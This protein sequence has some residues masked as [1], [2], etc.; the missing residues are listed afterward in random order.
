M[1]FAQLRT[2][3]GYLNGEVTSALQKAIRRGEEG[4][5]LFWATELELAGYGEY[6]WNR[7]RIISVEDVGVGEPQAVCQVAALYGFWS[8]R[9]KKEKAALKNEGREIPPESRLYLIMAVQVLARAKKCRMVDHAYMTFYE[10]DRTSPEVKREV[11][12]YAL[13]GHTAA[14]RRL[15]RGPEFFLTESSKLEN[16]ADLEDLYRELGHAAHLASNGGKKQ[17]TPQRKKSSTPA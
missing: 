5:A 7:L 4:D 15:G 8:D 16:E 17:L 12:D 11:P 1:H 14:G 3:G 6:V 13:D 10:G 9:V 2:P